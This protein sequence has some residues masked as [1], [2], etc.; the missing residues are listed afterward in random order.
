MSRG[1]AVAL[2]AGSLI[3]SGCGEAGSPPNEEDQTRYAERLPAAGTAVDFWFY[4]HCGVENARI[5]GLW[6]QAAHPLYGDNGP[7]DAPDGWDNPYQKGRLT[8]LSSERAT[9]EARGVRVA[10]VPSPSGEPLRICS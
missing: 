10:L 8:V 9:F 7:G 3:V 4:T 5:G 1:L 2:L 6:W